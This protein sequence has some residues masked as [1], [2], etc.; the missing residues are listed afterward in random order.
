MFTRAYRGTHTQA[1][2][3]DQHTR[4]MTTSRHRSLIGR[5]GSTVSGNKVDAHASY[6]KYFVRSGPH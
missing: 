1:H 5:S 6:F 2:M 3:Y 4:G